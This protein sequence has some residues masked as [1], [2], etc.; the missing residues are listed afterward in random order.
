MT[1]GNEMQAH[2]DKKEK[3]PYDKYS[4]PWSPKPK[5]AI[6]ALVTEND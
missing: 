3:H 1:D 5:S 2:F 4:N 6:L